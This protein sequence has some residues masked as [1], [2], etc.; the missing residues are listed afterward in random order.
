MTAFVMAAMGTEIT[1][2]EITAHAVEAF[3][4]NNPRT[5]AIDK[6]TT[7]L[8]EQ[9]SKA[10]DML[11]KVIEKL[12]EVA[13]TAAVLEMGQAYALAERTAQLDTSGALPE[14][15]DVTQKRAVASRDNIRKRVAAL[16]RDEKIQA[17]RPIR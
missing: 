14:T 8:L 17:G 3:K 5:D 2:D 11:K 16:R 10:E 12:G 13:E 1:T 7:V 6:R 9:Q 15:I 4:A